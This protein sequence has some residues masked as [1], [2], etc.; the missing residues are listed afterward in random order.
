MTENSS[1]GLNMN[2][3]EHYRRLVDISRDIAS[4]LD[5]DTLLRRIIQAAAEM[6]GSEAAS[7]LLYDEKKQELHFQAATNTENESIMRGIIVPKNSL[8]GWVAINREPV[9]VA[10]VHKDNRWFQKVGE[11]TEFKTRSIIAVP[12]I[13]KDTLIGVLEALNKSEGTF[14]QEDQENLTYLASLA[15]VAIE[16]T[17]LFQQSDLISE[18]VHE[19]RTPLASIST[20]SYLLQRP[21]ISVEQRMELAKTIHTETQR[22]NEMASSFLDLARLESG[23]SSFQI[24][25][26]DIQQLIKECVT[27]TLARASEHGIQI[28]VDI[29]PSL[30]PLEADA[31]KM[32]QVILNLLSNAIKYNRANGQIDIRVFIDPAEPKTLHIAIKDTGIGMSEEDQAHLFERFFRSRHSERMSSG[33]GL[34]LSICK[35]IVE[36]HGGQIQVESC[37]NAGTTFT[38]KLPLKANL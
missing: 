30:P 4:T 17:R 8:A 11:K 37:L 9:I 27:I 13:A 36:A 21:E 12:M 5:L 34:G 7:I 2:K 14:T 16:N 6:S 23:R 10:D 3:L 25:S 24:N 29:Q 18:L 32:K 20:V 15:A 19:L 33:T 1:S 31:D 35:K 38:V 22:L 28:N 26:I